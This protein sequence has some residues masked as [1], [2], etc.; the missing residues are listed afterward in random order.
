MPGGIGTY[1]EGLLRGLGALPASEALPISLLASRPRH[2]PD[3]LAAFGLP[4]E[5]SPLPSPLL[6]RAW[7]HGWAGLARANGSLVHATSFAMPPPRGRPLTVTVHDLAWRRYPE[8][9]PA[10]GRRWH[11]ASLQRAS[12]TAAAF[13]VPSEL[14]AQELSTT[15]PGINE[16]RIRVIEHGVD[17]LATAD[18]DAARSLL[19]RHGLDAA[20]GYLLTL[21][22]LEPRKNLPSLV[23]AYRL[24]RPELPEPWPLVVVGAHGWGP[25]L[26]PEEG[27]VL[28]GHVGGGAL[29][30]LIEM[31]RAVAYVPLIEGYGLPAVEAMSL[32]APVVA[33]RGLPASGGAALEVDAGDIESIAGA[34][35][36]ASTDGSTRDE[37]I[38][39]GLARASGLT[40]QSSG[41]RHAELWKELL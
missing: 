17:H 40:W 32:G 25:G 4:L 35:V 23:R 3:R 13:V 31:A 9:Y 18:H 16:S 12:R 36:L 15:V 20:G 41:R 19:T 8:A 6:T 27:V 33:S 29:S 14:T 39:A 10:R 1:C 30:A 5:T 21:S 26:Q 38:A 7:D 22:T 11:E 24:A 28:V 37:L 2:H 34:L